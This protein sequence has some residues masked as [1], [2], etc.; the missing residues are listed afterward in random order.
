MKRLWFAGLLFLASNVF[1]DN[2][3]KVIN[4]QY[5]P[6]EKVV[7]LMLPMLKSGERISGTG[8]TLLV[9]VEP[10]TMT[11]IRT[12]LHQID[13]APVTFNVSIYQGDAQWLSRQN[14]NSVTYS[15]QSRAQQVRSQSVRVMSG[16]SAFIDTNQEVPIV[17]SVGAG[18]FTGISYQQHQVKNGVLVRPV[19]RGSQVQLSVR[20]IREQIAPA[21][22]QQ[23]DNQNVDTTLMVPLNQW[24]A[25]GSPEGAEPVDNSS[26]SYSA[27]RTFAV[28]STLYVKVTVLR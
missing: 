20:R 15:T 8:Q 25:L 21:G 18:F 9:N 6:A 17:T 28:Q 1:A 2:I 16:E 24:V 13:V 19:L 4:L 12:L 22:G 3:A 10:Q 5:I 11:Q 27:G 26:T 14:N 23:F 7:K